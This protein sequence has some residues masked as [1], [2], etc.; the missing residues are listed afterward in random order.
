VIADVQALGIPTS[1]KSQ[2]FSGNLERFFPTDSL[3]AEQHA[4][5]RHNACTEEDPEGGSVSDAG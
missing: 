2:F 1:D 3:L 4:H 5:Q